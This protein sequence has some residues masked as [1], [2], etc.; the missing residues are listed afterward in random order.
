MKTLF[1]SVAMAACLAAPVYADGH[2][3]GETVLATVNGEDI[4]LGHVVAMLQMLPAEYQQLPDQVLFD[5]MLEQLVQQQ[6]LADAADDDISRQVELGLE[7][8]RRAFLAAMYMDEVA[9]TELPEEEVQAAYDEQYGSVEPERELNAAHILVETEEEALALIEELGEGAEFAE[10]A[11]E[12]STGP[13][14]PNGGALGWFT[15]GMMVPEFEEAVFAL[16][17][18]EVSSPVQTQFGWHIILLNDAREQ[19]APTLDDVRAELEEALRRERVD[20]RL[21]ELTQAAEIERPEVD[22][23]PTLIRNLDLIAE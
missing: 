21:E 12:H 16:E 3:S 6:V 13:S 9:L 19:P 2:A 14:G 22:I 18:G 17:V 20:T 7:N 5:G 4:T 10:L 23:D 15:A 1:A 8:E 11:A